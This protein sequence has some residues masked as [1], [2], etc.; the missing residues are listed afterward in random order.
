MRACLKLSFLSSPA[1][2]YAV[3]AKKKTSL[4]P[5]LT[6]YLIQCGLSAKTIEVIIII[7][8]IICG[9]H[10]HFCVGTSIM[11]LVKFNLILIAE[12]SA[13]TD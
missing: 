13:Q 12:A 5:L 3:Q 8:I 10:Q 2:S 1:V 9:Y 7:I 11:T 4:T 6:K